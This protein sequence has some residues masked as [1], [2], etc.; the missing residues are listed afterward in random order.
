MLIHDQMFCDG[1]QAK[2]ALEA[3]HARKKQAERVE[4]HARLHAYARAL[5]LPDS[6]PLAE[7]KPAVSVS[8]AAAC[9]RSSF[10]V[11]FARSFLTIE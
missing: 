2:S 4:R 9:V 1:A 3:N 8:D 5:L 10:L 7:P 6:K 11:H